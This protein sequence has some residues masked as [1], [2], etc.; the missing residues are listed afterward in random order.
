MTVERARPDA[1]ECFVCGPDNPLG[2]RLSFRMDGEVCRAEFVPG[3]FHG[4]Y[5]DMTHGG[6]I[7]SVLDDVMANWL[8]LQGTRAHTARCEIRYREPL[9]IG[10]KVLLEGRLQKRKGRLAMLQATARRASD[11]AI[12][13]EAEGSFLVV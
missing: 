7:Y 1:N 11:L 10:E 5:D 9:A 8:F 4:G 2:L 6:I 3:P 13:A 12:V